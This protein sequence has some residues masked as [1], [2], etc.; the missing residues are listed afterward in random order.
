M[1]FVWFYTRTGGAS[2]ATSLRFQMK[3]IGRAGLGILTVGI[4]MVPSLRY[5]SGG[6]VKTPAPTLDCERAGLSSAGDE[7]I[8]RADPGQYRVDNIM[9]IGEED[10]VR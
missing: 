4:P 10:V 9:S 8:P 2:H 7:C 1:V 6:A 3:G 5:V